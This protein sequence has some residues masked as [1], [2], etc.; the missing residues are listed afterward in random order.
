MKL[1][2]NVLSWFA[3]PHRFVATQSQLRNPGAHLLDV[4]CANN[5]PAV[6]KKYFPDCVYHGLDR[7]DYNPGA[8]TDAHIDKFYDINLESLAS[9]DVLTDGLYDAILCSHIL[10]H[11][12]DPYGV[13][14]SLASKLSPSGAMYIESPA[15]RS[16]DFP[17]AINGWMGIKGC[18]NFWDDVT[19]VDIVDLDRL[20]S[21]L[22]DQGCAIKR[23]GHR[24]MWRRVIF[25][26]AYMAAGLIMR[27]YI[28]ASVVWDV[29]RFA[30]TMTVMNKVGEET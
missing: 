6:A 16:L 27:G 4:G 28:P 8:A 10:E 3:I 17:R 18:L 11:V 21:A 20:A 12:G 26:P 13:A 1:F 14:L 2:Q 9:L 19:H 22:G 15:R 30:N 25:L 24:F 29:A 23:R 5:S 7:A